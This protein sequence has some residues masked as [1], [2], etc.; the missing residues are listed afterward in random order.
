MHETEILPAAN[1]FDHAAQFGLAI[2]REALNF[3]RKHNLPIV[4]DE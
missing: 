4:T 3:S 2:Y 1:P